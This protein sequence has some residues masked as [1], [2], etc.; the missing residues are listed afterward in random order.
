MSTDESG[1]EEEDVGRI[2]RKLSQKSS[3]WEI[4]VEKIERYFWGQT[5][6]NRWIGCGQWGRDRWQEFLDFSGSSS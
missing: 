5:D 1:E 2:V 3:L 6:R 4:E